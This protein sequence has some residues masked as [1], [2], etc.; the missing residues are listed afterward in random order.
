MPENSQIANIDKQTVSSA[1][2]PGTIMLLAE[3]NPTDKGH[4]LE[5]V[6]DDVVTQ[7]IVYY[8]TCQPKDPFP[9]D[10]SQGNRS[11]SESYYSTVTKA[12]VS[13]PVTWL[14]YSPILDAAY[15]FTTKAVDQKKF[16]L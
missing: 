15:W 5:D 14:G 11:F 8:A 10:P 16:R 9:K 1:D 13:V 3:V 2:D 7:F 4:F 6:M 12:G